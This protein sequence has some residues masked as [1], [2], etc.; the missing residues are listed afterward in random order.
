MA[1]PIHVTIADDPEAVSVD[2]ETGATEIRLP[3]GGVVVSLDDARPRDRGAEAASDFG[4]NL[5]LEMAEEDL[6]IIGNDL[7]DQIDADDRSRAGWLS[8]RARAFDLLGLK[9]EAAG[10]SDIGGSP[11]GI[12]GTSVVHNPLLLMAIIDGWAAAQAELLPA[13]GPVKIEEVGELAPDQET[14]ADALESD[15]NYYLTDVAK[16]YGPDTSHMLLWG[17]HFG[18]SGFKKIYRCPMRERPV[19]ESVS[20][21]H[22]IV[23][24]ATKDFAACGR[25]THEITMRPSVM[26]RMMSIGAYR[27]VTLASPAPAPAK[28][29]VD[30]KIAMIQ[31]VHSTRNRPEDEPFTLWECQ[32][33]LDLDRFAPAGFKGKG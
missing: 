8:T 28:S 33:E 22:L 6:G 5:A 27:D 32:C 4:A 19:S 2:P 17:T 24:D 10:K 7:W 23:S 21:E 25:I 13:D 15:M 31:G 3:D 14:L 29:V 20:P 26:K 30:N 11:A 1:E 9:I 18:G 16:E 12:E